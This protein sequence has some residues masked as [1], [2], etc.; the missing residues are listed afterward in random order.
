MKFY[1]MESKVVISKERL[2]STLKRFGAIQILL[3]LGCLIITF[4]SIG[5]DKKVCENLGKKDCCHRDCSSL[6]G[7]KCRL[8]LDK[9]TL[10]RH[11]RLYPTLLVL[12]Q[13][14]LYSVIATWITCHNW[15][16]MPSRIPCVFC[17]ISVL[18][19]I[20]MGS[21]QTSEERQTS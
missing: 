16:H 17:C 4:V 11:H 12:Q 6:Y 1:T 5:I 8:Q 13:L 15:P 19:G 20:T 10:W 14:T 7:K 9:N 21:M 3:G 18:F 2:G